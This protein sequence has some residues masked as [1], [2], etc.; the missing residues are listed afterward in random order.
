MWLRLF[1]AVSFFSGVLA[2][3][4]ADA[5]YAY[6]PADVKS[7]KALS[8]LAKNAYS[9]AM[10]RLEKQAKGT[11]Q[12][13]TSLP[14][15]SRRTLAPKEK[16]SFIEAVKCVRSKPSLYPPGAVPGSKSLYD[17]F[18]AVHLNQTL[19]IHLTGT[20]LT[21]HRYYIH[22][23]ESRLNAC[24]YSGPLPYWE[25]GLDT[26]DITRSPIFDGSP[27]SLGGNGQFIP[28]LGLQMPQPIPP[29]IISIPP[30]TG[31][32]CV[33]TGPFNNLTMRLGPVAMPNYG[34]TNSTS[35]ADPLGD[36]LR[37][38]KRD[39]N[40]AVL[41][42]YSSFANS[43][44]LILESADVEHFQAVMQ[45]DPRY[46]TG[47][48][49]VHGGGHFSIGGDPGSDPFISPGDPAFWLHHGQV[50][51]LYW[52][53]Q[54][55]DWERRQGVFGTSTFLSFPPTTDVTVED[56]I[57]LGVLTTPVKIKSLMS[58]TGG[59]PLCYVYQ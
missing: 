31:S 10:S 39:L 19:F 5:G 22:H 16:Q 17:D 35:V 30:G 53:W 40:T 1:L 14:E 25:W 37:C 21:W 12:H 45:A 55:L 8:S 15:R 56:S 23:Y 42:K 2:A 34:N 33:T 52:I 4:A 28:H 29:T 7:G 13:T 36:N 44:S 24:G 20:F 9:N 18:I 57:D 50:D 47:E 59:T 58:T 32:G 38:L 51:R 49:G 27:L 3:P 54:Q 46:I 48:L 26:S 11:F 41:A 6:S 43:T